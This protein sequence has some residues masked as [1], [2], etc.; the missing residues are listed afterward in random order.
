MIRFVPFC[1]LL[2]LIAGLSFSLLNRSKEP[3][4]FAEGEKSIGNFSI[5]I[6]DQ[7]DRRLDASAWQ[8]G[9][10]VLNVFASWCVPCKVEH[11]FLLELSKK[12][13]VK[14]YGIAWKD[15][16]DKIREWLDKNDNPYQA[17]GLDMGGKTTVGLGLTGVPET[18]VIARNGSI[19]LHLKTALNAKW[20]EE[21]ATLVAR[22]ANEQPALTPVTTT[23]SFKSRT[24]DEKEE[25]RAR[26]LFYTI[27][28][29]VCQGE[30]IADSRADVANDMRNYIREQIVQGKNDEQ[31]ITM[32]SAHYGDSVL[33]RPPLSPTTWLL[34]L[35]PILILA[36]GLAWLLKGYKRQSPSKEIA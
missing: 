35:A 2:A 27:R 12:E 20:V 16:P 10:I 29:V 33:M 6:L 7:Q 8:N 15:T 11:P 19:L 18:F 22:H 14:L 1:V 5:P 26:Q 34:W 17:V 31:I 25:A 9:A 28:C 24:L 3:V 21:I 36:G 30:S 23:A 32:L 4:L 13:H